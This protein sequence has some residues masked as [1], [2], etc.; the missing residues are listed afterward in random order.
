[1]NSWRAIGYVFVGFGA[2][3]APWAAFFAFIAPWVILASLSFA[4]GFVGLYA[5]YAGRTENEIEERQRLNSQNTLMKAKKVG[6]QNSVSQQVKVMPQNTTTCKYLLGN[7]LCKA[8]IEGEGRTVRE[9]S[10][11][12]EQKDS[13]CHS[14]DNQASC[15]ISCPYISAR[16][17]R[18]VY[19][20]S[21]IK[22]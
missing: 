17:E 8:A 2:F 9:G 12:N 15:E 3:I 1:M 7:N 6:L 19:I 22:L 21:G 4:V 5:G 11:V 18:S 13:C 16:Q 10:C 20:I 14:C